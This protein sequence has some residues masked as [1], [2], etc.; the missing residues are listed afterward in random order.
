MSK[1]YRGKYAK[2]D[3]KQLREEYIPQ[4]VSDSRTDANR[5]LVKKDRVK[6][7]KYIVQLVLVAL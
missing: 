7:F 1:N 4:H 5:M 2:R 6:V 3:E